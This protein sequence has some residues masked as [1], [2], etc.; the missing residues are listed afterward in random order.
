[1][2]VLVCGLA[3]VGATMAA[4]LLERGYRVVGVDT[5]VAKLDAIRAGRSPVN[6]PGLAPIFARGME[7]GKLVVSVDLL[8][9]LYDPSIDTVAVAVGTPA[10]PT[11]RLCR[12]QL[13]EVTDTIANGIARRP[14]GS[15]RPLVCYRSTMPP[16][17]CRDDLLPRLEARLGR[18]GD[19]FELAYH[20]EFLRMGHA[21]NDA[22]NPDRIVLGERFPGASRRLNGLYGN[23]KSQVFEVD[24]ASAELAKMIDNT[25]RATKVAFANDTARLAIASGADSNAVLGVLTSDTRHNMATTYLQPGLPY[26]GYCLPKDSAGI[27]EAALEWGVESPL[28]TAVSASNHAHA[29]A[30]SDSILEQFPPGSELLQIGLGFKPG[31]DDL[32]DS[33]LLAL[34]ERLVSAGLGLK[35]HDPAFPT[36]THWP[37]H[38]QHCWVPKPIGTNIAA[39]IL[40]QPWPT[41]QDLPRVPVINLTKLSSFQAAL[42]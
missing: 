33:P 28:F 36:A 31:S 4:W 2:T 20:P 16:G 38:L 5:D 6:E 17:T 1:M 15:Q 42:P 27:A 25:W 26:G 34:A 10:G 19:Q 29:R 39:I 13:H 11:K 8:G 21:L 24:F 9:A 7:S 35:I 22:R 23:T 12:R 40:G 14:K 37:S 3:T 18:V 32:R 30:I 41:A